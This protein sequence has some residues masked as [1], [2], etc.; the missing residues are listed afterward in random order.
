MW[1]LVLELR[2]IQNWFRSFHVAEQ[3]CWRC[4]VDTDDIP[5]NRRN[6]NLKSSLV[7]ER[8]GT[9]HDWVQVYC[10][11]KVE[12]LYQ[13]LHNVHSLKGLQSK[14]HQYIHT[15]CGMSRK[16]WSTKRWK[17]WAA[18]RKPNGITQNS[19]SP[20]GVV[21]AVLQRELADIGI[22]QYAELMS[23]VEKI[24]QPL[25]WLVKSCRYFIG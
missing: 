16:I 6:C 18:L 24:L 21:I 10:H 14:C 8:N 20:N 7:I 11:T 5:M 3:G 2:S 12:S 15:I 22:D 19:K 25:S 13:A 9:F 1:K 4:L 17:V 23:K